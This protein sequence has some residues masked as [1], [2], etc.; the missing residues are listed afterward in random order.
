MPS[1]RGDIDTT[2]LTQ[3]RDVFTSGLAARVGPNA[4]AVWMAIKSHANFNTGEAWCGVRKIAELAGISPMT[5]Q[6]ALKVLREEHLLRVARQEGQRLVYVARERM[7]LRIGQRVIATVV[8]DYVPNSMRKRLERLKAA[9]AGTA[10]L[11]GE[12]V[13]AQVELIPGAGLTWDDARGVLTG[14]L[15]A[16]EI[17][18][19][20]DLDNSPLPENAATVLIGSTGDD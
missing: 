16:D 13:W 11:D 10:D 8:I 14:R 18:V 19:H 1:I 2:Y 20:D 6:R 17:P 5:A 12:D 7:D 4:Y 9:A 3:Q 15:R